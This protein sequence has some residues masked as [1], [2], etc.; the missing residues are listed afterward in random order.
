MCSFNCGDVRNC[1]PCLYAKCLAIGLVIQ[2]KKPLLLPS[3]PPST[4]A[5]T[6]M[7][8]FFAADDQNQFQMKIE[9]NDFAAKMDILCL[10]FSRKCLLINSLIKEM[11]VRRRSISSS[12][13]DECT[14]KRSIMQLAKSAADIIF[15]EVGAT[16]V[17]QLISSSSVD[18]SFVVTTEK[19]SKYE[20]KIHQSEE[21]E[22]E[23]DEDEDED[24]DEEEDEDEDEDE[25]EEGDEQGQDGEDEEEVEEEQ[26]IEQEIEQ[27]RFDAEEEE[28]E[29]EKNSKTRILLLAYSFLIE[30]DEDEENEEQGEENESNNSKKRRRA[31]RR[32]ASDGQ[33][34]SRIKLLLPYRNLTTFEVKMLGLLRKIYEVSKSET[35]T[36]SESKRS[37]LSSNGISAALS[38]GYNNHNYSA[39]QQQQQQQQQPAVYKNYF[40]S[41]AY[42][43]PDIYPYQNPNEANLNGINQYYSASCAT[44][45]FSSNYAYTAPFSYANSKNYNK[46]I[47]GCNNENSQEVTSNS[48][49]HLKVL[50]FL[51]LLFSSFAL[52]KLIEPGFDETSLTA[53]TESA[54]ID[55]ASCQKLILQLIDCACKNKLIKTKILLSVSEFDLV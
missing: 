27:E 48:L 5:D 10:N 4:T 40:Y 22:E 24:E 42:K 47:S 37:K 23:D 17:N 53:L 1:S 50:H 49:S 3:Q 28:E 51:L 39:Y 12:A 21:E 20:E 15:K 52:K 9:K 46:T 11:E 29:A 8:G 32:K 55:A 54:Y 18:N 33:D 16:L 34:M 19:Q 26:G 13:V 41:T 44:Y 43:T 36:E 14:A 25:D 45:P 35:K 30:Q 6:S 31:R 2:S 7:N 38:C